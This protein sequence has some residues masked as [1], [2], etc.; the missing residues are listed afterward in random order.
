MRYFVINREGENVAIVF[1]DYRSGAV[2][3]RSKFESFRHVFDLLRK[4]STVRGVRE[5]KSLKLE[6]DDTRCWDW[7]DRF[8]NKLVGWHVVESGET[9]DID[10]VSQELL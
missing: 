10:K 2:V 5:E 7:P 1:H 6:F 8:L 9:N 3:C 4:K